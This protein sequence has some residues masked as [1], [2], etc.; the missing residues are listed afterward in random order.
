[1]HRNL[2]QSKTQHIQSRHNHCISQPTPM[3]LKNLSSRIRR[4]LTTASSVIS[5]LSQNDDLYSNLLNVATALAARTNT[6]LFYSRHGRA[7][8]YIRPRT[9]C[10]YMQHR[11]VFDRRLILANCCDK[12]AARAYVASKHTSVRLPELL[13]SGSDVQAIPFNSFKQPYV[14][15][16]NHACGLIE[17]V[18]DPTT[19][20]VTALSNKCQH[21]LATCHGQNKMEWG[22]SRVTPKIMVEERI[23]PN[24]GQQSLVCYKFFCYAGR[25]Q[26]AQ[27][28]STYDGI[29]RLTFFNR[30][31]ERLA[32]RKFTSNIHNPDP[33]LRAP[34]CFAR[35]VQS[36]EAIAGPMDHLRVDLYESSGEMI[37]SELT[38]YDGSGFSYFFHGEV[39]PNKR[40]SP[41][42]EYEVGA[43]WRV[44]DANLHDVLRF[45]LSRR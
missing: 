11:K 2:K 19:A 13:W 39:P 34:S 41:S 6:R 14:I 35:M 21:W 42:M 18:D 44:R 23:D 29:Y 24:P 17:F 4:Q 22:Y 37:L 3:H 27:A 33:I 15:K 30:N 20:D 38:A 32:I 9:R 12:L 8:N 16:P 1:M 26:V 25:V 31:G 28:E 7:P 40:P 10:D 45:V 43:P 5:A 36:A